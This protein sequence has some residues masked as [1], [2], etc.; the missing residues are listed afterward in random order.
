MNTEEWRAVVG[1]EGLYEVSSLGLVRSV[2]RVRPHGLG[3]ASRTLRGRVIRGW[4]NCKGYLHVAMSKNGVVEKR[5]VHT[6]VCDAFY[7]DSRDR[8][9][10]NH[11]DGNKLNNCAF[12][13]E[14]ST[15]SA[16]NSHAFRTGLK[17]PSGTIG[18]RNGL[19]KL[20][21]ML[22]LEAR[23]RARDGESEASI[24]R[25]VGVSA[26]TINRVISGKTWR[27]V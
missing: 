23:R 1:Y 10:T 12:N 8:E 6:I 15:Y 22:V 21:S 4:I 27:H 5:A 18:E 16:N 7:P 9:C 20:N 2:D 25:E 26:S 19:S 14:P 11:K 13:I 24:A 3:G 17:G